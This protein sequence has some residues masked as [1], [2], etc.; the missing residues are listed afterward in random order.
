MS[1][2]QVALVMGR[3]T[4][5]FDVD[6]ERWDRWKK[7]VPRDKALHTRIKELL[8]ADAEGRVQER[9]GDVEPTTT[10][11]LTPRV[12]VDMVGDGLNE[13]KR[14]SLLAGLEYLREQGEAT[15][16]EI[17]EAARDVE[18]AYASAQSW[19]SNLWNNIGTDLRETGAV[20]LAEKSRGRWRWVGE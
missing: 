8:D 2:E 1:S 11:G 20:E 4:F 5:S 19:R 6:E 17:A 13:E 7:T 12:V 9:G 14:R 18:P 16:S 3:K 15:T 10:D